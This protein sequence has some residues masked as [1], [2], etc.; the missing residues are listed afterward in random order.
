[1]VQYGGKQH[2]LSSNFILNT[3]KIENSINES[4]F[5]LAKKVPTSKRSDSFLALLRKESET[6]KAKHRKN[7][8][9]LFSKSIDESNFKQSQPKKYHKISFTNS[10]SNFPSRFH[11]IH[12]SKKKCFCFPS[13]V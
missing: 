2:T 6:R 9:Y 7:S 3:D 12:Y 4:P 11:I 13:G 5:I 10:T 1:M 8:F